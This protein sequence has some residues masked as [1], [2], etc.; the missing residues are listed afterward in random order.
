MAAGPSLSGDRA[1]A[2][3]SA[4]AAAAAG[5]DLEAQAVAATP[6]L[7]PTPHPRP[8]P[9]ERA[10]SKTFLK[11]CLLLFHFGKGGKYSEKKA[12]T[13]CLPDMKQV[14][15]LTHFVG[16]N[17]S[18][19]SHLARHWPL[20]VRECVRVRECG[21]WRERTLELATLLWREQA[22][23]RPYSSIQAP[24]L[25]APEFLFGVQEELD[26][27]NGL[28][29]SGLNLKFRNKFET[30]KEGPQMRQDCSLHLNP[31]RGR[32]QEQLIS[33]SLPPATPGGRACECG[34]R[35]ERMR[36]PAGHS[37]LAGIGSVRASEQ[38]PSP[39]LSAFGRIRSCERIEE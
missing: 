33:L 37:S 25:S 22:L 29:C 2:G 4:S 16:G 19:S 38:R 8:A 18:G 30:K 15:P 17:G 32:E 20:L 39:G 6:T 5:V 9:Q 23:C 10:P 21:N 7:A 11:V 34:N 3:P 35:S 14:V 24:V 36:E 28:K 31:L 27:P 26:N 12:T 1:A 13:Y